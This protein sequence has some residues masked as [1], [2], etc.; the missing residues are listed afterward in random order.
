LD[1]NAWFILYEKSHHELAGDR[2]H[3]Q[4]QNRWTHRLKHGNHIGDVNQV[5]EVVENLRNYQFQYI[6]SIPD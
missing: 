5:L 1:G 2:A 3:K 6:A 4:I